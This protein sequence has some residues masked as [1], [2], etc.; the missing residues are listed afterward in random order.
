MSVVI[1]SEKESYRPSFK[2][3]GTPKHV[4]PA[5]A[6]KQE[7]QKE[8]FAELLGSSQLAEKYFEGANAFLARGHMSPDADFTFAIWQYATYFYVNVCPQWQ[9]VNAGNWLRVENLARKLGSS[10]GE[11]LTIYSGV[12]DILTLP[13]VNNNEVKMSIAKDGNIW[14]PKWNWKIVQSPKTGEGIAFVTLNNPYAE[15]VPHKDLLCKD[16]CKEAGFEDSYFADLT[17]GY[18]YCCNVEDLL[19]AVETAPKVEVKLLMKA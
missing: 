1:D 16:I 2:S 18:T 6:Y 4:S 9:A 5:E 17:R 3:T 15:K 13:D 10:R 14:V 12:H 7:T 11:D 19:A 8:I